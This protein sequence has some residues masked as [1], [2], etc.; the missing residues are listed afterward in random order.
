MDPVRS[1][2]VPTDF[3][4]LSRAA[5]RRA[6]TLAAATGASVHLV[7]VLRFPLI[8]TPYE[9][10][11][12]GA[13]WEAVRSAAQD[14]MQTARKTI[15]EAG[16]SQVT[17]EMDQSPDPVDLISKAVR[18]HEAD[19]VV[20]GTHGRVG[21]RHTILGSVAERTLRRIE[22]PVWVVKED[23]DEADA[24]I[25]RILLA[26]DFSIHADGAAE[27]ARDLAGRLGASIDVVHAIDFPADYLFPL[28][29]K[30]EGKIRA[31]AATRLEALQG[32]LQEAG[33]PV[34]VHLR[35]GR[36]SE[37]VSEAAESLDSQ[38][39][40]MGR[41]GNSGLTSVL[42]GSVAERTLRA[43]PCSVLTVHAA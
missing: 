42:L 11:V 39:I 15:E 7:H 22:C 18:E 16:V 27:A 5:A 13:V 9:V 24:P 1:I 17:G 26:T 4:P 10:T 36:A 2:V 19:L 31:A 28:E 40:V 25:E 21:L 34:E 37:V 29:T 6:A 38:L 14:E 35:R 20:M 32:S 8:A 3:R 30:L 23:P 33:V 43:A 41:R 12:P